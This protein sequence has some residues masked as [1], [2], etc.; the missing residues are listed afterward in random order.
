MANW[1]GFSNVAVATA[2]QLSNIQ[3]EGA[4]SARAWSL[5]QNLPNPFNP[6][7]TI[8]YALAGDLASGIYL[9]RL[10]AGEFT[11]TRKMLL[12]R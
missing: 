7:T 3:S 12:M 8:G 11:A 2:G 5:S 10:R 1:A 9:Y 4:G 6:V